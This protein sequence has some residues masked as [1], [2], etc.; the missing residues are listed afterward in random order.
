[1]SFLELL[2]RR[3][4][5]IILHAELMLLRVTDERSGGEIWLAGWSMQVVVVRRV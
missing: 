5:V 4:I 1:M 3:L 2:H